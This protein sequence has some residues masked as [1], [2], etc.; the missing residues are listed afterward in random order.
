MDA[1]LASDFSAGVRDVA[2]A[3]AC[4]RSMLERRWVTIPEPAG[5]GSG[6]L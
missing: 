2:F 5:T 1:P 6:L 3:Q 4:H